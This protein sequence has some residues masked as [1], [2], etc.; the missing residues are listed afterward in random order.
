MSQTESSRHVGGYAA[1]MDLA[2]VVGG[3][4]LV[5]AT[6]AKICL[7]RCQ[8]GDDRTAMQLCG[9]CSCSWRNVTRTARCLRLSWDTLR[10]R[11][12]RLGLRSSEE[13]EAE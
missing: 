8:W 4:S 7:L 12:E 9:V 3:Y 10:Y 6:S 13:F 5:P 2:V 1:Y 11:L